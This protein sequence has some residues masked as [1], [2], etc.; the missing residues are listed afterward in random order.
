MSTTSKVSERRWCLSRPCSPAELMLF[1]LGF[2]QVNLHG[3]REQ[4]RTTTKLLVQT[5]VNIVFVCGQRG[6]HASTHWSRR[7]ACCWSNWYG[8]ISFFRLLWCVLQREDRMGPWGAYASVS[9]PRPR[10]PV[11]PAQQPA[12]LGRWGAVSRLYL[13]G[14]TRPIISVRLLPTLHSY[15]RL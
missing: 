8:V 10:S 7:R 14:Q 13:D 1:V 6:K 3:D 5:Y 2:I 4:Y 15:G 12:P 9:A 11:S